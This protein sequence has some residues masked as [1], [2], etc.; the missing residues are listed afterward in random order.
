MT[1]PDGAVPAL[2]FHVLGEPARLAD[3]GALVWLGAVAA[4]VLLGLLALLRRRRALSR[5]GG[6]LAPR[7]APGAGAAR[8]AARLGL[9]G[10]G[11]A[12]LV[13]A[14]SRPQCG[15]RTEL[16]RR[17]GLD[18]VV[19]LDTS[20]SM[21][22]RDVA[23]DRL[24]RARLEVGELLDHLAGDRAGIVVFAGGAFVL[25]PL[26]SD[27]AAARLFLRAAAPDAM[28]EQGTA[29]AEALAAAREVLESAEHGARSKVVLVVSDGEDQEGG[30][31]DAARA[32]AE[33]G[34]RVYAL[35]VG[36]PEGAPIP[37]AG[38][39]GE[40]YK[41]DRSGKTVITKLDLG[42]LR[43]IASRGGGELFDL[44]AAGPGGGVAGFRAALD[45]L[46]R[47]ERE[48]RVAV[49]WEERY[50]AFAFPALLCLLASLCLPERR[51]GARD[52]GPGAEAV[53][54]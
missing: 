14:L 13:L 31:A 48:G 7:L 54:P 19:V 18:L 32:L 5:A 53:E 39:A 27:A 26:T 4:V 1:P 3:P 6:P 12:L 21:L 2:S 33:A 35:A 28:P 38:P 16:A 22:A 41:K 17:A 25:C 46:E 34:I 23:P 29:L 52:G 20:R 10:T 42:T 43:A 9:A 45:R 15:S 50:A 37:V 51:R 24:S 49:S 36:T 11:L 47:T 40:T 44:Q 8:P 30:A